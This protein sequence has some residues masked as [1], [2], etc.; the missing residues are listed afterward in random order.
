[1]STAPGE[2]AG[3]GLPPEA[4]HSEPASIPRQAKV[5]LYAVAILATLA[6]FMPFSHLSSATSGWP[7][8]FVLAALAA[9]AQLFVVITPR[10]QSYHTTNVFLIAAVLLLPP[11]LIALLGIVY[12]IPEWLKVRYP[13]YIQGFNIANHT[14]NGLAAWGAVELVRNAGLQPEVELALAGLVATIVFVSLNHVLLATMLHFARGHSLRATGLFSAE[15]LSTDF[16]LAA[17]GV[18]IGRAHV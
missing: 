7:T 13:W 14:L 10:D 5:Y 8:F 15:S 2:P 11:E 16:V 6:A 18:E 1:M 4:D 3:E 17:L 9:V 12:G